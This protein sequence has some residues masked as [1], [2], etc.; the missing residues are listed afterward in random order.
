MDAQLAPHVIFLLAHGLPSVVR[1]LVP[2]EGWWV[3]PYLNYRPTLL[4]LLWI[5]GLTIRDLTIT[6]PPFWTTHPTFC[7]QVL[8]ESASLS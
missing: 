5:Q 4:G 3:N 7:D 2:G 1:P 8:V 6:Q